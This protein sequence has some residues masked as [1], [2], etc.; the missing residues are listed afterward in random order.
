MQ[1]IQLNKKKV[2]PEKVNL[3]RV[4]RTPIATQFYNFKVGCNF[5]IDSSN[6]KVSF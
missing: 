5:F 2:L 1:S 6:S 3:T 4:V